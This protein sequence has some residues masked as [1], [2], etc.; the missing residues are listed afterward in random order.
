M[1]SLVVMR[2]FTIFTCKISSVGNCQNLSYNFQ[3]N[4]E[5]GNYF[6]GLPV[7][8]LTYSNPS[9]ADAFYHQVKRLVRVVGN[10]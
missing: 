10:R 2:K 8:D 1:T 6:C 3:R 9:A 4:F 5:T 7:C